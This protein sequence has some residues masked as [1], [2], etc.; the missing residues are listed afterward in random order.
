[1]GNDETAQQRLERLQNELRHAWSD[2]DEDTIECLK[3][4]VEQARIEAAVELVD[5][6]LKD[7]E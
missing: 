2:G 5:E 7:A 4:E 3:M 6:E 1:M